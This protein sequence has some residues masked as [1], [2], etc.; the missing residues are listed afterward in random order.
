MKGFRIALATL[1]LAGCATTP[2]GQRQTPP[3]LVVVVVVDQLRPDLLDRYDSL[4]TGG[5]RRLNDRG[6]WYVNAAHDHGYTKTAPGHATLS[7]GVYPS[8]SGIVANSWWMK[9]NGT[10]TEMENIGDSSSTI[11]GAPDLPGVSPRNL[12][13]DGFADWLTRASPRSIV[14]TVSAK[15]RGAVLL[16]ARTRG[17]VYWFA[18]EVGRFVTSIYY[19]TSDP[20]WVHRFHDTVMAGYRAD[21]VW[22]SVVPASERWRSRPDT[23]PHEGDATNTYFPHRYSAEREDDGDGGFWDWF[24]STPRIDAA[25]LDFASTMVRSLSLGRDDDTDLLGVS[26]SA[27][28]RIGHAFGPLSREQ[29]DNLLRLDRELGE[30]FAL[31]DREVGADRYVVALSADHGAATSPEDA[32]ASGDARAHRMTGADR[33]ALA[34]AVERSGARLDDAPDSA[35][36]DRLASEVG[37]LPFVAG[38]YTHW[39]LGR[40]ERPDSFAVLFARSYHPNRYVE[41]LSRYG[42]EVLYDHGFVERSTGTDHGSPHWY[43][44]LVPF[45]LMG[46]GIPAGQDTTRTSTTDMAPTLAR[47]VGIPVPDDLDGRAVGWPA[48]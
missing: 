44:R 41:D 25:T 43:D 34:A 24:E 29:L 21:S 40:A 14:A 22:S 12:L 27:T 11:V 26:L 35:A 7:T 42:V 39:Q 5:L 45:V 32:A 30:F 47:I 36:A 38:A 33:A 18:P 15:D 23:Q 28:D 48:P 4:Y 9:V 10:W 37:K 19:R 8:R 17:H 3:R 31:L 20:D 46:P 16:A 13:R 2:A 1:M 6:R